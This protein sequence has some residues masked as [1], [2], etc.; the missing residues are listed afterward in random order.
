MANEIETG[1]L[2]LF[3]AYISANIAPYFRAKNVMSNLITIEELPAGSTAKKFVVR[4]SHSA[5]VVAQSAQAS[6]SEKTDTSV[7]LTVQKAVVFYTPTKEAINFSRENEM[8]V[9]AEEAAAACAT[10]FEVDA[11]AL[12]N[13]LTASVGSTGVDLTPAVFNEACYKARLTGNPGDLGAALH[14]TQVYDL[15]DDL[16][17]SS[18]V[19]YNTD[20]SI[21]SAQNR[22]SGLVGTLFGVPV[23]ETKN[24][25]SI[26]AAADWAGLVCSKYAIA[27]ILNPQFEVESVLNVEYALVETAVRM[28]YQVGEWVDA[29]GCYIV[30]DQ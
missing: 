17:A 19:V 4:G 7:S 27:A 9:Q 6:K 28:Y 12:A 3:D 24:T 1:N 21:V 26:N 2:V 20:N 29:A 30:S 8:Q 25:E 23:Y 16:I 13:G 22:P 15:R 5:S 18:A 14:N 11:L 10:K